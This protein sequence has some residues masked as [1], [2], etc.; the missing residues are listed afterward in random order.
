MKIQMPLYAPDDNLGTGAALEDGSLNADKILDNLLDDSDITDEGKDEK[1]DLKDDK[2]DEGKE[3]KDEESEKED[4]LKLDEEIDESKLEFSDLPSRK[5]VLKAFPDL[6]KKFPALEKAIYR[7]QQYSEVFP[8]IDDAKTAKDNADNYEKFE[9]SLLDGNISSVL[10]SVKEADSTAF[11]KLTEQFLFN[12]YEVDKP[13][14]FGVVSNVLKDAA[15]SIFKSGASMGADNQEGQNLRRAAEILHKFFFQD[16]KITNYNYKH[17]VNRG[18]SKADPKEEQLTKREERFLQDQLDVASND[19]S[20]SVENLVRRSVDNAIDPTGRMSD[21]VKNKAIEDII[22][23]LDSEINSDARFKKVLDNLWLD[24]GKNSFNNASKTK[25][26]NALLGKARTVLPAIMRR[27]RAEALKG[28]AARNRNDRDEDT[29][30]PRGRSANLSSNTSSRSEGTK[31][32]KGEKIP[33]KM[34][35][36]EYLNS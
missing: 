21:Y 31:A 36:L 12:L 7:E 18:E 29:P 23:S 3:E 27:V 28:S 34:T 4:E 20:S 17:Q 9:A 19:V 8:N 6:Y 25:I 35:T 16:E 33:K 14:Y 26:K 11:E 13:A 15:I 1:L 32:E 5:E 24:S 2:K 30:L 10:K 22:S